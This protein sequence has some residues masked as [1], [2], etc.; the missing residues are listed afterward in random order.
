MTMTLS[1]PGLFISL[2]GGEGSGKTTLAK[3]LKQHFESMG[4]NVLLTRE[5]GGVPLAENIRNLLVGPDV[6]DM[7]PVTETLLY[8]ASRREHV[9]RVILPALESGHIVI[10]DRYVDS[11][12]VYQGR[13]RGVS[14]T[15]VYDIN[16]LATK[17]IMPH[18]TLLLNVDPSVA[19]ERITNRVEN[20]F[21]S[22]PLRFHESIHKEYQNLAKIFPNRIKSIDA[23]ESVDYVLSQAIRKLKDYEEQIVI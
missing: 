3:K 22:A 17:G 20:R 23:N 14:W 15:K 8:A 12:L 10:S 13:V 18:L 5:P 7:D 16:H 19:Q 6:K 4:K 21:D 11:S 2:E 9:N 1:C